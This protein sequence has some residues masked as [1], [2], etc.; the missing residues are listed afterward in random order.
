MACCTSRDTFVNPV[1]K[2]FLFFFNFTFWL[3]GLLLLA[4]GVW[5]HLER[6]R[7]SFDDFRSVFDFITDVSI[8]SIVTGCLMFLL[9]FC[10]CLGALRENTCLIK[11]YYFTL[12]VI[13]LGQVGGAVYVFLKS[14]EFKDMFVKTL[15]EELVPLYT[16][17]ADKKT[18]V[19]WFQEQLG[20]CGMSNDGYK[21]WNN[22]EYFNCTPV[23]KSPL[24]CAVPHSCCIQQDTVND[25][26]PNI[27]CGTDA[28]D[29]KVQGSTD[30]IYVIGCVS[31][32]LRVVES[33]FPVVG[34]VIIC[35]ALPQILGIVVARTL[36]GQ[37]SDQ[38]ARWR[39]YN[40][41]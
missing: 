37:I 16:E 40:Q 30:N 31:A 35:I 23:N 36:D 15:K 26:V 39:R 38:L 13:F 3:G 4:I 2:Y 12:C 41:R 11:L 7:F 14:N 32:V 29:P 25:G 28:L 19:D 20:C 17:R 33:N 8:F 21:D 18:L 34:G 6:D 1:L 22:N 24:A 9:G 27:L 5:A 10:G